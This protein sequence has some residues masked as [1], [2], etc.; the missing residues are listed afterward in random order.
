M[1]FPTPIR[2]L[3]AAAAAGIVAFSLTACGGGAQPPQTSNPP[4]DG[5]TAE[6]N[7]PTGEVVWS[8]WGN[9]EELTRFKDFNEEFM[10]R[11]PGITVKLQPVA[12]YGEYHSKLLAQLTS[13]TAPD[14]F[15][16]GD[17]KLGQ[18]TS[19]KVLMPLNERMA[20]P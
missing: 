19:A 12:S 6:P 4:T 5:S 20:G 17:D 14:V 18:F 3:L 10:K 13:R 2:R 9:P 16:I 8:T 15:Y 1:S 11:H 7:E